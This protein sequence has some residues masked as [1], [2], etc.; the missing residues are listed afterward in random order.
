M[1]YTVSLLLSASQLSVY[2]F[3]VICIISYIT[4]KN[5][6]KHCIDQNLQLSGKHR[7]ATRNLCNLTKNLSN[8]TNIR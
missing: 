1:I 5:Q 7:L 6:M 2:N 8:W 4:T 3:L